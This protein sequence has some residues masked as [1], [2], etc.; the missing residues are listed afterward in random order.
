M[1]VSSLARRKVVAAAVKYGRALQGWDQKD[2]AE[3]L[4]RETTETWTAERV[5]KLE[6]C[7]LKV[8]VEWL[9]VLSEVQGLP[10]DFY[11][12]GASGTLDSRSS[13]GA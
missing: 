5:S 9:A 12:Y 7:M 6:R 10:I 11:I 8:D 2:L 3:A 13:L 4:S 1:A